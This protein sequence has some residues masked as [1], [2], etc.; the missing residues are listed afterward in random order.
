[1]ANNT[2]MI[3]ARI[4]P[5]LEERMKELAARER[6]TVSDWIRCRLEDAVAAATSS[7]QHHSEAA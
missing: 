6:R 1:M 2:K 5:D 4:K 3:G 7:D